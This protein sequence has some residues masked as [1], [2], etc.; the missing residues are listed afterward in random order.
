MMADEYQR[1]SMKNKNETEQADGVRTR[2]LTEERRRAILALVDRQG[3]ALISDLS[4]QFDVSAVTIRADINALCERDLLIRSHG[5]AFRS[6]DVVLDSPLEVKATL[7]HEEKVRIG[8][9]AAAL[10][11]EGEIILLDSGTTTLEVS[12]ALAARDLPGL[13]A[14]TNALDIASELSADRHISVIMIGGLLRHISRSF[15]GPQAERML[16]EMH[17]DH[18]F[19][20]V[21]GLDPNIGP[22]TPDVLEAESNAAMIRIARQVTVVT[23]SSKIGR[24]SLCTI[25][26]ITSIHRIITDRSIHPEHQDVLVSK[27][28]EVITV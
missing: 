9:A 14:I 27:G 21:D 18:L 28:V 17:V 12:R 10:V 26:P 4:K 13:T 22:S 1:H 23:D 2:M 5:G 16:A 25:S 20:G 11:N 3:S 19:L 8:Q 15:V 6:S 24:R 7:H